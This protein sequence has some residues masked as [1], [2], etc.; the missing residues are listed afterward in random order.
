MNQRTENRQAVNLPVKMHFFGEQVDISVSEDISEGG[1]FIRT[2]SVRNLEKG[3]V[4]LVSIQMN[5]FHENQYLAEV[6][7]VTDAGAAFQ[8]IDEVKAS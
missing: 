8:V 1:F 4:A 6:I 5:D 2:D 3:V 7:R